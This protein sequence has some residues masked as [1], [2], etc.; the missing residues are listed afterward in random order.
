MRVW[1][2]GLL[3]QASA[4]L[5]CLGGCGAGLGREGLSRDC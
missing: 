3:R 1:V 5:W 4:V 2:V